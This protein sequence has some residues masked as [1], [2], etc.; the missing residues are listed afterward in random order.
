MPNGIGWNMKRRPSKV[1]ES[2]FL[3]ASVNRN[4]VGC[5][6]EIYRREEGL[7]WNEASNF[8]NVQHF[9]CF[10]FDVKIEVGQV[11]DTMTTLSPPDDLG[12][13]KRGLA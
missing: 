6:R 12:T 8:G 7:A 2:Y 10:C 3:K 9:E 5:I 1:K 4:V 11:Y 13:R